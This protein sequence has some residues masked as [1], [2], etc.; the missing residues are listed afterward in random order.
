MT[1]AASDVDP[2]LSS[3]LTGPVRITFRE[4]PIILSNRDGE[5]EGGGEDTVHN[6]RNVLKLRGSRPAVT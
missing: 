4:R 1:C 2:A 6:K 3:E 5:G